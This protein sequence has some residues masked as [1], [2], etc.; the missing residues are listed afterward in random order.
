MSLFKIVKPSVHFKYA[1]KGF[2][3]S[4]VVASEEM[5]CCYPAEWKL[6]SSIYPENKIICT[7]KIH[8]NRAGRVTYTAD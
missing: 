8:E 3:K 5:T 1:L 7:D 6:K 4:F 2:E